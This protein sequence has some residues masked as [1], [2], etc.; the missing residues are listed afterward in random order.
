[1]VLFSVDDGS[2]V[3]SISGTNPEPYLIITTN[4]INEEL[5]KMIDTET[6]KNI[7][8]QVPLGG[9]SPNRNINFDF[10][11]D[12]QKWKDF[13]CNIQYLEFRGVLVNKQFTAKHLESMSSLKGLYI[14]STNY[15]LF[16]NEDVS[17]L[18]ILQHLSLNGYGL[19][20]QSKQMKQW[21]EKITAN[22]CSVT[23]FC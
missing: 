12:L 8:F 3:Y 20:L 22:D 13:A 5:F 1:M 17:N 23:C 21:I 7:I 10:Q 6:T 2:Y 9:F 18:P 19:V 11:V 4:I 15:Y 14:G 16:D